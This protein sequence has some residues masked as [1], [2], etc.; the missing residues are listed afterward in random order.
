MSNRPSI[1]RSRGCL[2]LHIQ[3]TLYIIRIVSLVHLYVRIQ[4]TFFFILL[5]SFYSY[6][7]ILILCSFK[8]VPKIDNI[9]SFDTTEKFHFTNHLKIGTT[10]L[11]SFSKHNINNSSMKRIITNKRRGKKKRIW[12]SE[13]DLLALRFF[14]FFFQRPRKSRKQ[15]GYIFFFS[16][17][18]D[19]KERIFFCSL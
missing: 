19:T 3:N 1:P 10:V 4:I 17:S 16:L 18:I 5:L 2:S 15:R 7:L 13:R 11:L 14:F 6:D 12:R 8:Y 9:T